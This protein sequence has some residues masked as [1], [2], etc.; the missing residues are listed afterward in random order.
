MNCPNCK[1]RILDNSAN[2]E[3]CGEVIKINVQSNS[4][5][6]SSIKNAASNK[7][8]SNNILLPGIITLLIWV[9]GNLISERDKHAIF[10]LDDLSPILILGLILLAIGYII[11]IAKK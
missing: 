5:N 2:C 9:I 11:K 4:I 8:S 3:W 7:S 1:N 6:S 10:N